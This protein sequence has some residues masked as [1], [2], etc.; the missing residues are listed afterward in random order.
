MS[1]LRKHVLHK[2]ETE[3]KWKCDKCDRAY[4][5]VGELKRHSVIHLSKKARSEI[6]AKTSEFASNNGDDDSEVK[7][8]DGKSDLPNYICDIC[9][10]GYRQKSSLNLHYMKHETGDDFKC[11]ICQKG[12]ATDE[13]LREHEK[14]HEETELPCDRCGKM[15]KTKGSLRYH[16]KSVHEK[17]AEVNYRCVKCQKGFHKQ[18]H[19]LCHVAVCRSKL[20]EGTT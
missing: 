6:I 18:T 7:D 8:T 11:I 9:G 4:V 13:I 20:V 19:F 5:T 14:S 10:A 17:G 15:L 16:I 2:H 3:R 12:F 1:N